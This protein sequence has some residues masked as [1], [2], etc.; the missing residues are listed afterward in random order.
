[1]KP[2]RLCEVCGKPAV[3]MQILGCCAMTVC[4]DHAQSFLLELAPGEKKNYET[5]FYW[6]F[7]SED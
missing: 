5:C 3:G 7:G 1:M 2:E 4:A 6:R